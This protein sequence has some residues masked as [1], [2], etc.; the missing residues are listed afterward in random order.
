MGF[1]LSV[2]HSTSRG[3]VQKS[4]AQTTRAMRASADE[5]GADYSLEQLKSVSIIYVNM[6]KKH[7]QKIQNAH[8]RAT[9]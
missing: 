6:D 5:A 9:F 3:R 7:V 2:S 1:T 4:S 8:W